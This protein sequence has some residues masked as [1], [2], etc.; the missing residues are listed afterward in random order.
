MLSRILF[1]GLVIAV[2]CFAQRSGGSRGPQGQDDGGFAA[3]SARPYQE[4]RLD[5]FAELLRLNKDQK[6]GAKQ[7]FDAAQKEAEPVRGELQK[8]RVAIATA[9]LN[10]QPQPE[11]DQVIAAYA[12]SLAQMTAIETRAFARLCESLTPDQ[13]KR[14]GAAFQLMAG[15]FAGRDWNH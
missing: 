3:L 15:M 1:A 9:Y 10:R 11:I 12:N 5:R 8:G 4:S 13:Q 7:I 2:S 14:A 6:N